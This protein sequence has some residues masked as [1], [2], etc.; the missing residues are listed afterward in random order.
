MGEKPFTL[1]MIGPPHS[2]KST[3]SGMLANRAGFKAIDIGEILR[4]IIANE[5]TH[6]RYQLIRATVE[7]GEL[8]PDEVAQEIFVEKVRFSGELDLVTDGFP[9]TLGA[10]TLFLST[11]ET[12]HRSLAHSAV[13]SLHI[14]KRSIRR[15]LQERGREDDLT[16]AA[17]SKRVS[18]FEENSAPTLEKLNTVMPIIDLQ[19]EDG[20]E[21]NYE[22]LTN[23]MDQHIKK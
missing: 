20:I 3:L 6:H 23:F 5:A 17:I 21:T 18:M 15:L 19:F 9:R 14:S 2:G 12:L 8:L 10:V 7:S 11:M 1:V 4:R 16:A 13:V 22:R